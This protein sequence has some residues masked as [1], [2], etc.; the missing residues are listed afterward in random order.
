MSSQG[1]K[2]PR[3]EDHPPEASRPRKRP[4]GAA[5]ISKADSEAVLQRQQQ[6]AEEDRHAAATRGVEEVVRQHYNAVPQRGREWRKTDSRIKGLR[7]FNNWI[8][9]T[10]IHKF[11][12]CESG[13]EP[14]PLRVLDIGCGKGGDLGK[15]QQAPQPVELYVG[16]DPAEVSIDQ[17]KERFSQMRSG[18]GR[19]S[20]GG[21]GGR[22]GYQG[23]RPQRTFDAEFFAEDAFTYSLGDIPIIREVGFGP[24]S[25]WG[26][27]GGFDVVSMMFCMH[28][29]FEN[30]AKAKGMLANVAGSLKKGGRFLGVAPNS[31]AIRLG[32]ETFHER[33]AKA[34]ASNL[35]GKPRGTVDGKSNAALSSTASRVPASASQETQ[36]PSWKRKAVD[37]VDGEPT[38]KKVERSDE[39]NSKTEIAAAINVLTEPPSDPPFNGE[40]FE[41]EHKKLNDQKIDAAAD[42]KDSRTESDPESNV[43]EGDQ[44]PLV[45]E[46]GNGIYR[47][48]FPGNTPTDGIFR[49]PYGW[50]YSYFLEEAVEEVPEYVVPWEA[51]R[52][53]AED[54]NLE[55]QYRKPFTEV[56]NEE[57]DSPVF[58][59]LSER[60]G[61]RGR[62][63]GPLLVSDEEMEAASFYHAFC[64][65][66]I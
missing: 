60:M 8:K 24:G 29:A 45:A 49:P 65:Y 39:S 62:D 21:R 38:A 53:I 5:R 1:T 42:K 22:G 28:Y 6:R 33:Q 56:W 35:N 55:L 61:V 34:A 10:I 18:G 4:G 47:V 57:K 30:E 48:R 63:A 9:S 66:K 51:F 52:A 2:R 54:Y 25:R 14:L 19:A 32:V 37:E 15:W 64:F 36:A 58:G 41:P 46:W 12:P 7:S 44:Q 23:G 20:R 50:K 59:P 16:V 17:A 11:S 43:P 27:G 40:N 31:D 26:P 3:E 13:R